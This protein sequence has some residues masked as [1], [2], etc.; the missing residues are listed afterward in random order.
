MQIGCFLSSEEFSPRDLVEQAK[1]AEQAGFHALWISDHYHPWIDEQG[2]SGFVWSVIGALSEAVDLPVTTG[3][4]CPTIRIHPAIIAQAAATSAVLTGGRFNL[5]VGS[6]EALNEH[7]LGTHWPE[8]DVR[9]EMLR[10]AIEVMRTLWQ[11]GQQSHR[12]RHYTVENARVYDLPE[13]QVP[14]FVSGF[15]PKAVALAAEIG[16]GFVTTSPDKDAI[17]QYRSGGG[18]GPV[19]AG[20]K[21]CFM[22]SEEAARKTVH[23]LWPNEA[24]PGE[25]AQILPTPSHFEQATELV[26]PDLLAPPMGPDLDAHVATLREYADAGVDELFVQQIGPA[27]DAFFT[28][29]AKEVLPQFGS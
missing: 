19:H 25:L 10:E 6:G 18:K 29:W 15:G 3:V 1:R 8:A 21:V 5:G 16:D 28:T 24:L 9:L 14:V 4:T 22:D 27:Q 2:H 17:E 12:G 20:T 13:S 26:T 7:I 11:G 23:R